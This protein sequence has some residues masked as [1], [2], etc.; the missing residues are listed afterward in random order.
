MASEEDYKLKVVKKKGIGYGTDSSS[1]QKWDITGQEETR[2][3]VHI[4]ILHLLKILEKFLD[5]KLFEPT[6][7]IVE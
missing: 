4:Q 3:E 2:K 7:E 5:H 1:N 6:K